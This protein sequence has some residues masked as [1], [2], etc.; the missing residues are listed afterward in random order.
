M[1]GNKA[2]DRIFNRLSDQSH[3]PQFLIGGIGS[4][5]DLIQQDQHGFATFHLPDNQLQF[6][7]FSQEV[8]LLILQRIGGEGVTMEII[9]LSYPFFTAFTSMFLHAGF[10]HILFNMMI[11]IFIGATLESR[12]GTKPFM[13]AYLITGYLS[14]LISSIFIGPG[15]GASGAICGILGLF[16]GLYPKEKFSGFIY[17]IPVR[18]IP[19]IYLIF[20]FVGMEVLLQFT[21][22]SNIGHFT[23]VIGLFCGFAMAPMVKKFANRRRTNVEW[24]YY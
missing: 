22:P 4:F 12:I 7:Y 21:I 9:G 20:I 6:F 18:N 5:K 17:F 15:I 16:A 10:M 1:G 14:G 2:T 13:L 24:H 23:H 3:R 19:M 8:G 11:L